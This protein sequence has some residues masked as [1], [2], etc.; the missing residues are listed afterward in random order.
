MGTDRRLCDLQPG[1]TAYVIA[2]EGADTIYRRMLDI[3]LVLGAAVTCVGRSPGGDPAA[4]GI[5]GAII[6]IRD[7][8]SARIRITGKEEVSV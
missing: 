1:E 2:V 6:A 7:S 4:Y 3:G 8:E 5:G